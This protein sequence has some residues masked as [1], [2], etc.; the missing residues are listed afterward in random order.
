M[1]AAVL[2][3]AGIGYALDHN[4]QTTPRWT[5]GLGLLGIG[6]GLYH[7]VREASR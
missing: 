5:V 1:L 3:G 7:A 4:Y 2:L 6:L